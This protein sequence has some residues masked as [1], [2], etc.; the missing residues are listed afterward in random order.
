MKIEKSE[1]KNQEINRE[2]KLSRGGSSSSKRTRKSQVDSVHGSAT[3]G[4]RQGPTMT[5]DSGRGISIG[6]DKRLECPHY[7]KNHYGSCKRV[8]RG[9]FRCGNTNHFIVNCP[10][11]SGSSRN[12]QGSSQGGTNVPPLTHD[13]GRG[14]GSSGQQGRS[15]ASET[16]NR[17]TTVTTARAYA[18]RA[19]GDQDAP[20]VITSN[21]TLY[22]NEMHA[23]VD[24]GSTH[25]YIC[26]K[27]L[28]DKL[29]SVE[30]LAYDMHV[31]SPLGNRIRVNRVYK[32]CSLM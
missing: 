25:S 30:P 7:H 11:G 4:R 23:L 2:R 20:R 12:S 6:Q 22:N 1:M 14:R 21:F 24:P 26:I 5:Q 27:Q 32:N 15:I 9:C 17:P 29:P 13:K 28:S 19:R 16:V 3:R 31:T 18:M 8:T 10:R